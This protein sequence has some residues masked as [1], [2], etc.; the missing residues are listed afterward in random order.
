MSRTLVVPPPAHPSAADGTTSCA[1][2]A[3]AEQLRLRRFSLRL[4]VQSA[5]LDELGHVNNVVYLGWIEQVARAHAESVGAGFAEMSATGVVAV[6]R[7][8]SLHYHR[9]ALLGDEVE[10]QTQIETGGGLRAVR[11]NRIVNA[12][13]GELLVDGETEWVWINPQ[14]GRPKRPPQELLSRFGY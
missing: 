4:T 8:H 12:T 10:I 13:T 5:E 3:T 6:V 2:A 14:T 1:P 7:K 9:S 11:Q